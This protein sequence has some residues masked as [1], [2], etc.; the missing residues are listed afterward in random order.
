LFDEIDAKNKPK[1]VEIEYDYLAQ[2]IIRY[3]DVE[4]VNSVIWYYDNLKRKESVYNINLKIR[5]D[6]GF[7]ADKRV[8]GYP[9]KF[10][11][12]KDNNMTEFSWFIERVGSEKF[13]QVYLEIPDAVGGDVVSQH[14]KIRKL[15]SPDN[16]YI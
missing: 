6:S 11:K 13:Q 9:D 12:S 10:V 1:E 3:K 2:D 7:I 15:V 4:R 5:V 14:L 16:I 8:T